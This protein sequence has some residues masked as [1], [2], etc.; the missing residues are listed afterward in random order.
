MEKAN[1]TKVTLINILEDL[2]QRQMTSMNKW[3]ISSEG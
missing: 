3:G 1:Y 2:D